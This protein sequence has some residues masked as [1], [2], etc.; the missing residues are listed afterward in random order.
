MSSEI[1]HVELIG[2]TTAR[3]PDGSPEYQGKKPMR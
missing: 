1:S 2:T 3:V